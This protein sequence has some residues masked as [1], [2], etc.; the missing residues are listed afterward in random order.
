LRDYAAA[1]AIVASLTA[2]GFQLGRAAQAFR[3]LTA[4]VQTIQ[5]DLLAVRATLNSLARKTC[6]NCRL[7]PDPPKKGA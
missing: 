5:Q 6:Q 2:C 7:P 3:Q 4:Q 1:L